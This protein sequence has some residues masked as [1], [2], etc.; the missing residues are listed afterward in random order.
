MY[1]ASVALVLSGNT[2]HVNDWL[3]GLDDSVWS[4]KAA[5]ALAEIGVVHGGALSSGNLPLYEL[6]FDAFERF[7]IPAF[8]GDRS[9]WG[10][11]KAFRQSAQDVVLATSFLR[12][13]AGT[14]ESQQLSIPLIQRMRDSGVLGRSQTQEILS[15]APTTLLERAGL[16][17]YLTQE[18]A[19]WHV[20]VDSF[21]E[22]A[23]TYADLAGIA[24]KQG[25]NLHGKRLLKKAADNVLG[26]GY[27]KD[28]Y[29]DEIL[30]SI[31]ACRQAGSARTMEW[32]EK[33]APVVQSILDFTDG[34]ET[35]HLPSYL[36]EL[37]GKTS[38][39]ALNACYVDAVER[40][41][42]SLAEDIFTELVSTADFTDG[43]Q[44]MIGSTATNYE[45][46]QTIHRLAAEGRAGA[47]ELL[48]NLIDVYHRIP[49]PKEVSD[50]TPHATSFHSADL[51][52]LNAIEP[53]QIRS[54]LET[55][56]NRFEKQKCLADWLRIW[57]GKPDRFEAVYQLALEWINSV[58]SENVDKE[59][60][61][62][63]EPYAREFDALGTERAFD[64]FCGAY[65]NSHGW[66]WYFQR[67]SEIELRWHR[68]Q[69]TYPGRWREFIRKTCT[70]D[71]SG[72][73]RNR[74]AALPIPRGV[75]FLIRY[76]SL[77]DAEDLTNAAVSSLME[78]MADV[79]LPAAL[80]I[81][82]PLD[83]WDVLYRRLI[84]PSPIVRERAASAFCE[85]I[86]NGD[87]SAQTID[88][89][90]R[91]LRSAK[92]ESHTVVILL[93]IVKAVR[94]NPEKVPN[95]VE[96]LRPEIARPSMLS[97]RFLQEIEAAI[98]LVHP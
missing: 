15:T 29:V 60:Y 24:F 22:R 87:M 34:D 79:Q 17:T 7:E 95:I 31:E 21:Y 63:L 35:R 28:L 20:T 90:C 62:L 85:L 98:G 39:G 65:R 18:E 58:G 47:A 11:W 54:H 56:A 97:D 36:A 89:L 50:N 9:I 48:A 67:F 5:K 96:R 53:S 3:S 27:H 73:P 59:V 16:E 92:L 6:V 78:M 14:N 69:S 19:H 81:Q 43:L 49:S 45:S 10:A 1:V 57:L 51:E 2:K 42:L 46:L 38:R 8:P 66:T 77:A 44:G 68:L 13:W 52:Q 75:E 70:A 80:W 61:D 30:H 26:Y 4:R 83:S 55:K 93:P 64:F 25:L 84:W 12:Y 40:G 71:E 37:L 32:I 86:V 23:V 82:N 72:F 76:A 41:E 33:V 88:Y 74:M 94:K 91:M